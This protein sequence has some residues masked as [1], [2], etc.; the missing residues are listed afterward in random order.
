MDTP[1]V[2]MTVVTPDLML[3]E[4]LADIPVPIDAEAPRI[5]QGTGLLV[6]KGATRTVMVQPRDVLAIFVEPVR[7]AN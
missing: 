6:I 3:R 1:H 5:D 4:E 7:E 2:L